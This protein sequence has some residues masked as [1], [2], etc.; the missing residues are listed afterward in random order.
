MAQNDIIDID[1]IIDANIDL[2]QPIPQM[3]VP[4]APQTIEPGIYGE[5][6]PGQ[7]IPSD[8]KNFLV[9]KLNIQPQL[10]DNILGKPYSFRDR[11]INLNPGD[12]VRDIARRSVP[13]KTPELGEGQQA[14]GLSIGELFN[15]TG[16]DIQAA[17]EAGVNPKEGAPYQVQKDASYLPA[18]NYERGIKV[19]LREAYPNVPLD[20][21]E[22]ATEPRTGRI[23]YKDPESGEKQFVQPPGIDWA[24]VTAV[25]EPISLEIGAGIAGFIAGNTMGRGLGAAAG[26][27][28]SSW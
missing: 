2:S 21:L 8:F 5:E 10:I 28:H 15:P 19:L 7:F 17:E 23:V 26:G 16:P 9:D 1:E 4:P 22:L 27:F 6:T 25:M 24:D 3:N 13:F 11:F 20:A 14:F 12:L 18:D